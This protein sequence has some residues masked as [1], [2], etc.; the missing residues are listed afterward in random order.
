MGPLSAP[1]GRDQMMPSALSRLRAAASIPSDSNISSLFAP[2]DGAGP[3][4]GRRAREF[5]R[6]TDNR[7][8]RPT[9]L[10]GWLH[11]VAREHVRV[12]RRVGVGLHRL[13]R[14]RLARANLDHLLDRA[15]GAPSPNHRIA[16]A[17]MCDALRDARVLRIVTKLG[18]SD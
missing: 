18:P 11:H 6:R 14:D 4:A 2:S 8:A 9:L 5:C 17:A 3:N 12:A 13:A 15:L 10:S 16:L 1:R 7:R